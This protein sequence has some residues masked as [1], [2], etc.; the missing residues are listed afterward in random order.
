[1]TLEDLIYKRIA[2]RTAITE[3]LARFGDAPAVF[4]QSAPGDKA[5]GWKSKKQYPRLDF[6]VDMQANPERQSSGLMA[7]NIWCDETG[8]PPEDVEPE[9]RSALCDVF[10]QPTG[11]PPY[12]LTWVRSDG[13]EMNSN[14]TQ[15]THV[16]G[17]TV[18]FDVL[19]FPSQKTTDPDPVLAMNHFIKEWEPSVVVIGADAIADYFTAAASS[20]AFYFRLASMEMTRETNTVVWMNASIACHIF[21]PTAAARLQWIKYL[22]DTLAVRGEITMLDT[23]PMFLKVIKADSAVDYL[24]TGQLRLGVQ[25]GI[26]R[27]PKY[28]H[29]MMQTNIP[30]EKVEAKTVNVDVG[31]APALGYAVEYKL[32]GADYEE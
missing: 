7:L 3:M 20:P 12:C 29:T 5:D 19:A 27:R 31:T 6:A 8:A 10:M 30:R 25:F 16:T 14:S 1:M 22:V 32:A 9:V 15:G 17:I 21:A 4:Y 23:S 26:L 28:A 18:L 13:F 24:T 11:Q 2:E